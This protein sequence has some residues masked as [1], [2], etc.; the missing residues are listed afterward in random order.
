MQLLGLGENSKHIVH[1]SLFCPSPEKPLERPDEEAKK[2][3]SQPKGG[4]EEIVTHGDPI[5]TVIPTTTI[6]EAQ[7]IDGKIVQIPNNQLSA[8]LDKKKQMEQAQKEA[9]LSKPEI[10][11]VAVEV[12]NEVEVLIKGNK[13]FL[14]HQYAH[15]KVLT[16]AHSEKLKQK[17]ELKK[18]DLINMYGWSTTNSSLIGSL[19]YYFTQTHNQSQ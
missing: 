18:K 16:I 3:P 12:V 7:E 17:A 4:Q 13:D 9:E 15:L 10:M 6:P 1:D 8:G 19:T 2:T 5:Q 11:K 14:K